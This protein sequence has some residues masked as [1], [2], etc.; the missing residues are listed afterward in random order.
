VEERRRARGLTASFAAHRFRRSSPDS[1]ARGA[2]A[3]SSG[4]PLPAENVLHER[5]QDLR[6]P[7]SN[8]VYV[9]N[10]PYSFTNEDLQRLFGA[11]GAVRHSEV[12]VDRESGRSRGFGFVELETS[13]A[14]RAAIHD[15][16]DTDIQ[17]R[18]LIVNEARER[19]PGGPPGARSFPGQ[20]PAFGG[21]PASGGR[22]A[23][24]G[25]P[26]GQGGGPRQEGHGG[27]R[28]REGFA[29]SRGRDGGGSA[30][31]GSPRGHGRPRDEKSDRWSDGGGR[32]RRN[33]D[34]F[35]DDG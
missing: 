6:R 19:A 2:S 8:K 9:G 23:P 29:G 30:G 17:G 28:G 25:R 34:D 16:H 35:G 24:G 13:E 31:R 20:R 14:M 33:E 1:G 5:G 18:R 21:R 32:R 12:L 26:A 22:P 7:M 15:L 3:D 4:F 10:L 27:P 11:F